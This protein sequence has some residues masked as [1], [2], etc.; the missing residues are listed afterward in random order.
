[1]TITHAEPLS[2]PPHGH[3]VSLEHGPDGSGGIYTWYVISIIFLVNIFNFMDRMALA[4]LAPSIQ[5]EIGISDAELGMLTGL[6]Y[7]IFYSCAAIPI[8]RLADRSS[9]KN[10]IAV[11]LAIWSLMTALTGAA[12]TYWQLFIAR[13]GLGAGEAG[14]GP[15][16]QSLLCDY[17]SPAKR[18]L[19]IAANSIGYGVGIAVGMA[20]AG[21]LGEL[22]GWRMAF[23]A[24]GTPG[25][26]LALLVF[27]SVREPPRGK[28]DEASDGAQPSLLTTFNMLR[29]NRFYLWLMVHAATASISLFG[30]NQW[31]PIFL[32]RAHHLP[33]PSVGLL[34]G[35][36][37]GLGAS[38]GLLAGGLIGNRLARNGY[39]PALIACIIAMLSLTPIAV[40]A[41]LAT[42]PYIAIILMGLSMFCHGFATA[43]T[44]AAVYSAVRPEI[45]A[46][47]GAVAVFF[48]TVIGSS[49]G[50]LIVGIVSEYLYPSVGADALRNALMIP[51]L[52]AVPAALALAAAINALARTEV[53]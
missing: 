47:A 30:L 27:L 18:P 15:P 24:L 41:N 9:R 43:P 32:V 49:V 52:A 53:L 50:P 19:A 14:G 4:V 6:A 17:V 25:M 31:W 7:A 28:F 38:V 12:Q 46:T 42:A 20:L 1:M 5:Q 35:A 11:S 48:Q 39:R 44:A 2:V 21:Y 36:A 3:P 37:M 40:A 13:M 26:L 29:A 8:A 34:L 10:I 23:V 33:L 22:L 45:R 51:A 16:A